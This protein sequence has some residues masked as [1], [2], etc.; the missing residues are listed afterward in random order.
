MELQ[1]GTHL[2]P[3]ILYETEVRV[4]GASAVGPDTDPEPL[5]ADLRLSAREA[6][7]TIE[8]SKPGAIVEIALE[9][10][11]STG[12]RWEVV[13]YDSTILG[14]LD[15]LFQPGADSLVGA[16]GIQRLY[17]EAR[18]PGQTTL[19]LAY[20]RPWES[21]PPAATF[22]VSFIVNGGIVPP[23][24]APLGI[25]LGNSFGECLGYCWQE[26]ILDEE[27]MVLISRG[28]DQ[29]AFPEKMYREDMDP[30]LWRWL[31]SVA[32]FAILDR[33]D[34]VYGCPDCADG[35]AEWVTM[36]LSGRME[37]VK[38]EYGA[39]LEPI[40]KLLELLREVR[41]GLVKRSGS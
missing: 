37:T 5:P 10:N 32:D 14:Q 40:G 15:E 34:E 7:T 25:R 6:G 41:D 38:F 11:P 24:V 30:D 16:P 2:E 35:G 1:D 3:E 4:G 12:Y 18:A 17:F 29:E 21:V 9:A 13:R 28:W 20:S 22:E 19:H 23:P 39:K 27:S 33:M 31:L 26:M 36:N 8:L